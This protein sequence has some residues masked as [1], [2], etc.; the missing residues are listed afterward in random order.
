MVRLLLLIDSDSQHPSAL[1]APAYHFSSQAQ[2]SFVILNT[3]EEL[4]EVALAK[5]ATSP[6]LY[7]LLDERLRRA[8]IRLGTAHAANPLDDLNKHRGP[9]AEWLAEDLQQDALHPA[10]CSVRAFFETEMPQMFTTSCNAPP[11]ALADS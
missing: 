2:G 1:Y 3:L 6:C 8:V 5:A 10:Q 9:V 4:S 7:H 11:A